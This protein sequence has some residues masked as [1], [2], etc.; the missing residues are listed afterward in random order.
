MKILIDMNLSPW[1]VETLRPNG[2]EALHWSEIGDPRAK[3]HEILTWA[4]ERGFI[5]F[6]HDLDF[7]RVLALTHATGPSVIQIRSED[8]LPASLGPTV[9]RALRQHQDVLM[10]G[11]LVVIEP[12]DFRVRI[13]PI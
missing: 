7:G 8:V 6:T 5:V 4:R 2:I 12:A 11:A 10:S 13:L 1:W 9:L 3:D